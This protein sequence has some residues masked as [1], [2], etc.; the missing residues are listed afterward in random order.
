MLASA[1]AG[2]CWL[3]GFLCTQNRRRCH[4][5]RLALDWRK[6]LAGI[7]YTAPALFKCVGSLTCA[8]DPYPGPLMRAS[9]RFALAHY[10]NFDKLLT[11]KTIPRRHLRGIKKHV[12]SALFAGFLHLAHAVIK[13]L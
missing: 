9:L 6:A 5:K 3:L 1:L 11:S 4:L 12:L 7:W 13:A 8:L 10:S 2:C